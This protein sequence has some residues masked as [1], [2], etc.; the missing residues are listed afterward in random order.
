MT[1]GQRISHCRKKLHI[2][3]EELG[4]RLG[5][6]P[7]GCQQ[8]GNGPV[9]AGHEQSA[10]IGAGI[11][12]LCSRADGNTGGS[13]AGYKRCGKLAHS[14]VNFSTLPEKPF[15]LDHS[16]H[17]YSADIDHA[18]AVCIQT[19][20]ICHTRSYHPAYQCSRSKNALI[21]LRPDS[22]L[23]GGRFVFGAGQPRGGIS[24]WYASVP[25]RRRNRGQGGQLGS[26]LY[27]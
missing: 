21:R 14:P 16:G 12:R 26:R 17:F 6:Q 18:S 11:R 24:V 23:G 13:C 9:R 3:Q 2:S 27:D 19:I 20:R 4:S 7:S 25:G 5:D 1:L 8:M 15:A 22:G 10:G